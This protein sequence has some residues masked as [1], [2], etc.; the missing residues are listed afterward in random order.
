MNDPNFTRRHGSPRM[1]VGDPQ[2]PEAPLIGLL[3]RIRTKHPKP[4]DNLYE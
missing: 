2:S 3:E 1:I 4:T